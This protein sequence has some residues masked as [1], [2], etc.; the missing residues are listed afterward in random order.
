L[1]GPRNSWDRYTVP[2]DTVWE[3]G[4]ALAGVAGRYSILLARPAFR[5]AQ[6]NGGHVYGTA[7]GADAL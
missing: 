4:I 3:R 7:S 1:I 2:P 6:S 5:S